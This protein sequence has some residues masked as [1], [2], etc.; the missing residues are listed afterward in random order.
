MAL[1][2]LVAA[3]SADSGDETQPRPTS[4]IVVEASTTTTT[5]RAL[6]TV[7]STPLGSTSTTLSQNTTY[8]V[9][10]SGGLTDGTVSAL[11]EE[12]ATISVVLGDA[13]LLDVGD[14][15]VVPLD[16]IGIDTEEHSWFDTQGETQALRPG[17]VL[18][19]ES[20][21]DFRGTAVGGRL[22]FGGASFEV[23]GVVADHLVGAAEAIFA[24]DDPRSPVDTARYALINTDLDRSEFEALVMKANDAPVPPRINAEGEK[25]LLRHADGV[26]PQI[27]IK[28]SLGE[29]SYPADSG[30]KL[31]QDSDWIS[32]NIVT[33]EVPIL[34]RIT[35]HREIVEMATGAFNQIVQEG[36][37][38][39]IRPEDYA[40]CWNARFVRTVTGEPAGV[41]RH[42][43]GAAIDLNASTN[44]MGAEGDMDPRIVE[45]MEEW[46]FTWGGD[47]AVPDPMHF[48]YGLWPEK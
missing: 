19:G 21:A 40:G 4:S 33:A 16:A 5:P 3:C 31:E 44:Q 6:S 28:M 18:L 34:G 7:T 11:R 45:I 32:E 37:S 22:S 42:S 27:Y 24:S 38:E 14:G 25:P 10:T 12:F 30:P 9:W 2:L 26:L 36:L 13:A 47:W 48:E 29:F 23:L 46:G 43:W 15:Q 35:C 39:L 17:G 41:S 20:S 8:V 1:A